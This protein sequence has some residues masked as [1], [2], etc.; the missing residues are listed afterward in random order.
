VDRRHLRFAV[1]VTALALPV[2]VVDNIPRHDANAEQVPSGTGLGGAVND[3]VAAHQ[4]HAAATL[5]RQQELA[6]Q[7]AVRALAPTTTVAPTTTAPP[8]TT[9]PT[10]TAP[11][12][13]QP[14]APPPTVPPAPPT[15]APPPP[16]P[17]PPNT[18]EGTAS[19]YR[20]PG[21]YAPDGC[22]HQTLPFG[23]MVTV[24]NLNTGGSTF[25]IVS[26]RG[27]FVPGRIIDLDDDVFLRLAPLGAGVIPVVISWS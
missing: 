19:W 4:A 27:P 24:T 23:T 6:R 14:P 10:T 17:P 7:A 9:A 18:E 1:S 16:P 12:V 22:A 13:T 21:S 11:P 8:A 15:T 26:D 25:C 3:A 5:R 20:Q 2:L